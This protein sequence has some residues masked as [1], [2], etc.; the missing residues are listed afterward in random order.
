MKLTDGEKLILIMLSEIHEKL[1]IKNGIDPKFVQTA[2]YHDMLWALRWKYSGVPFERGEN[3]TSVSEVLKI[4]DMWRFVEESYEKLSPSDKN[5]VAI[6][7]QPFGKH[8]RFQGFDGNNETEHF[9][10]AQF[11]VNEMGE[12]SHFKDRDLNSHLPLSLDTYKRM[13]AVFEPMRRTLVDR[14]LSAIQIIELMKT[15][16]HPE[17]R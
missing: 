8:V 6:E 9:G 5:R 3:P 17:R 13:Y 15:K 7:A 11:L 4:L 10:I 16:I 2:I 12:F 1:G 14:D